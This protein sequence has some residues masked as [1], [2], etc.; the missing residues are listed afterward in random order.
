MN[1]ER[2]REITSRYGALSI[3]LVGDVALDRYLEIDPRLSEMSLETGLAVHNIVNIRSQAG[4]GGNVLANLAALGPK[5]LAVVGV[6]GD[7]GEGMELRRVLGA[8]GVDLTHFL[9]R[10]DRATVTYTKPLL[11]RPGH[12]PE[13]LNRLDLRSRAAT[14]PDLEDAFIRGLRAVVPA[15]DV[16]VAMDQ[17]PEPGTGVLTARV[18]AVLADLAREN[19]GKVFLADSRTSIGAF[20]AVRIKINR[21]ELAAHFGVSEKGADL[22]A[23]ALEWS[24]EIGRDVF[25][26][27]SQ[28]GIMTASDGRVVRVPGIPA[29]PPID[30]VGAGDSVLAGIAMA[31]GAGASAAEAAELGNLA[32]AVTVKKLGT[33]GTAS[34]SE[35]EAVLTRIAG[36]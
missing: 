19:P 13:E 18:K 11:V 10:A 17:V 8:M 34:P 1:L 25:V 20:T 35:L 31:L 27:L 14:P 26:T 16:V 21:T 12:P 32:G 33:T 30:I 2:F 7:E 24:K 9:T 6:S 15:A 36:R 5:R 28:D 22:D 29:E 23:M 3:A 4:A